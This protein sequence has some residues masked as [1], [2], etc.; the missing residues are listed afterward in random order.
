MSEIVGNAGRIAALMDEI[1]TAIREQSSGVVL[2]CRSAP[3]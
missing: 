3:R 1:A 2:V